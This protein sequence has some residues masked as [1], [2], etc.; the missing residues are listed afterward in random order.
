MTFYGTLF[1]KANV[2][3]IY[4]KD[5]SIIKVTNQKTRMHHGG[6]LTLN[7][8][9]LKKCDPGPGIKYQHSEKVHISHRCNW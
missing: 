9:N 6:G 5:L 1:L 2:H 3:M 7:N 8:E 4:M